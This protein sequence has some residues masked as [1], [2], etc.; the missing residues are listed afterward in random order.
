LRRLEFMALYCNGKRVRGGW[1][2]RIEWNVAW[3]S[4]SF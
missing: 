1:V 4:P 3:I 2:Y